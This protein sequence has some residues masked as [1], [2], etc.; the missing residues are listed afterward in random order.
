MT[1]LVEYCLLVRARPELDFRSRPE[2]DL[3]VSLAL[4][5]EVGL[6]ERDFLAPSVRDLFAYMLLLFCNSASSLVAQVRDSSM[7]YN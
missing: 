7:L 2:R 5:A 6:E 4:L 3:R 1:Y